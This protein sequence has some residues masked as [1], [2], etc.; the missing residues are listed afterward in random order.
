MVK[1][2]E[3]LQDEANEVARELRKYLKTLSKNNLI[4]EIFKQINAFNEQRIAN[5]LLVAK[6]NELKNVGESNEN[7]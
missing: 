7:T 3:E 5:Q 4:R 6:I 2:R 1:S